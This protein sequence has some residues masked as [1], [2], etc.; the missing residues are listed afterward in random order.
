MELQ[1]IVASLLTPKG[2]KP[3]T[4][5]NGLIDNTQ[6]LM[7]LELKKSAR[8]MIIA[9]VDIKD[10]IVN[11]SMGT[12]IDFVKT[13]TGKNIFYVKVLANMKVA[14]EKSVKFFVTKF[15]IL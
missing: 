13:D 15:P 2:Y 7:K 6:F 9:N 5:N 8:V 14:Q 10:S 11:G 3:K 12:I 1:E 4:N